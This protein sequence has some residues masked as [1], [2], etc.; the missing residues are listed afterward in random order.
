V[1]IAFAEPMNQANF[2][3]RAALVAGRHPSSRYDQ[4]DTATNT[5]TLHPSGLMFPH[6]MTV[7][8]QDA[9]DLAQPAGPARSVFTT[10]APDTTGRIFRAV[11][12]R[13]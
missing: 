12:R 6:V 1:D 8:G 3:G 2:D 9:F 5:A 11:E 7:K 10:V 13:R 4:H